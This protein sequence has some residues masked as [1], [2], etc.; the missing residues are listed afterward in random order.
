MAKNINK[1]YMEQAAKKTILIFFCNNLI[2]MK[3]L[4]GWQLPVSMMIIIY[5]MAKFV[6]NKI[7]WYKWW[8]WLL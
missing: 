5:Y 2:M 6:L 8:S 7:L 1:L 3:E 4:Y